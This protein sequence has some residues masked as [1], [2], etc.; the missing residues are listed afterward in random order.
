MATVGGFVKSGQ[1]LIRR[2]NFA[3][4]RVRSHISGFFDDFGNEF[5]ELRPF[6]GG[7]PRKMNAVGVE[8]ERLQQFS[9]ENP[10]SSSVKITASVMAVAG[11][12]TA[13]KHRIGTGFEGFDD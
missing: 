6:G 4:R 12:T 2:R 5:L 3:H 7:N 8:P 1:N 10:A 9:K 13:D 11:M